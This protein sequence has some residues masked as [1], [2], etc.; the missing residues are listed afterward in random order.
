M[1]YLFLSFFIFSIVSLNS[2]SYTNPVLVP[3][4]FGN[5]N[6]NSIAD[7]GV[8]KDVDGTYYMY[9]TGTGYPCFSSRDLV[10]W[11][12]EKKVFTGSNRKWATTGFWAPEVIRIG[13]QYYLN[14]TAARDGDSPKNIGIAVAD[15][16]TGPFVDIN[17]YPFI[18]HG[19]KGTID[20]HIFIDDDGRT[21]LY[22]SNAMSTNPI[23]ENPSKKRSE[24]WVVEITPDLSAQITDHVM[25]IYPQQSWEYNSSSSSYWNEGAAVLKKEGIYYLLFSANCYC[26]SNYAVGYATSNSPMGPFTKYAGNPILSNAGV[27]NYV[28]GPGHNSVV[29]SP[30]DSELFMVYHSHVNVG[31]LNSSNDGIRQISIDRMDFAYNGQLYVSGPTIDPQPYPIYSNITKISTQP[32]LIYPTIVDDHIE[33]Q[34]EIKNSDAMLTITS[35]LG[36]SYKYLVQGNKTV[37]ISHLPAA[38]YQLTLTDG[39][40][41][42]STRIIKTQS[43]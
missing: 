42:Y 36:Q 38:C 27:S 25:L 26:N 12:Y 1:R 29:R 3:G 33:I 7:P 6:I 8:F 16:P 18:D 35:M 2:Q 39:N 30:D 5:T 31:N 40:N 43:K 24:I 15:S 19:D 9:V 22:Y 10:N 17:E 20:S 14:Y 21:Y 34:Q 4:K 41:R 37:D 11:T 28:S 13:T 32:L 23:P